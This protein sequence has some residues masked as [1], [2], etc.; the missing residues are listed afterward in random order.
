[1]CRIV[2]TATA[3]A[4]HKFQYPNSMKTNF[5]AF[6]VIPLLCMAFLFSACTQ[7]EPVAKPVVSTNEMSM[8]TEATAETGGFISSDEGNEVTSRGVCWSTSPNPTIDDNFTVDAAGTGNFTS[9]L[10][11]LSPGTTYFVRAYATNKGGTAYGLQVTFTTNSFALTTIAPTFI[12]AQSAICGGVVSSD[13]DSI[14]V[15]ARG[16]CWSTLPNPTIA[17]SITKDGIGKGSFTSVLT[18]LQPGTTYYVRAYATNSIGT[19]YGAQQT[20]TTL[21]TA[22]TLTDIDGNVYHF[23]TIGT[24]TWMVESL[25]TTRYRDGT[26]IPNVADV[27][28]WSN[29]QTGAY[30]DYNTTSTFSNTYGRLYNWYA[31]SN[32]HNIAPAGW[33]VPTDAEWT[34]LTNYLNGENVAGGKLKEPGTTHWSSPNT[35]ATNESGFTAIPG[36]FR[37]YDGT[38]YNVGSHNY[39]WSISEYTASTAWYRNVYYANSIVYRRNY[40]KNAGFSVRCLR[41][42]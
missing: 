16:V 18:G 32:S 4:I 9:S 39:W 33:H 11:K 36:G 1:M 30:C 14:T 28:Q 37:D 15:K 34:T 26:T 29:L 17:D 13:G 42:N 8:I 7:E 6:S 22:G 41:D 25:K 19:S 35:S 12:V 40:S 3:S 23:V 21:A 31:M 38:F 20:F 27:A 2:C 24:Q 10:T 5:L